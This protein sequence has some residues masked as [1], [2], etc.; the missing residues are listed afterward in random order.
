MIAVIYESRPNVT[1]DAGTLCLKS[2]NVAILRGGSEALQTSKALFDGLKRG[3]ASAGLPQGA[4]QLVPTADRAAV[5][6]ILSGLNNSIDLIIPRGGKSLVARVQ[7]EA[8]APVLSHLDGICHVYVDDDA[9]LE[10]ATALS[11]IHI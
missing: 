1:I 6:A 7:S 8:R 11:L 3:I 10:K 2:G 9:D 4:V 5:G